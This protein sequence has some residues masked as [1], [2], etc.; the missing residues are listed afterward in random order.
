M[1]AADTHRFD[2]PTAIAAATLRFE[3]LLVVQAGVACTSRSRRGSRVALTAHLETFYVEAF[4]REA[5]ERQALADAA[6]ELP[7]H[8]VVRVERI[9]HV[10]PGVITGAMMQAVLP[11]PR[12]T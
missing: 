5:A 12:L 10:G 6:V 8:K 4:T 7:T 9:E 2:L 11:K 1:S 3:V